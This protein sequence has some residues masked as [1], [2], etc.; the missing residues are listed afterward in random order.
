I[1]YSPDFRQEIAKSWPESIDDAK[2]K[3]DWNWEH[4]YD[5]ERMTKEMLKNLMDNYK[6]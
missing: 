6:S 2:A 5:L 4:S 1:S 3:E